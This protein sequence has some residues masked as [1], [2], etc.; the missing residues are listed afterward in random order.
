MHQAN[1]SRQKLA[2]VRL[3]VPKRASPRHIP[4][5]SL[6]T[7]MQL[8]HERVVAC[9]SK[10]GVLQMDLYLLSRASTMWDCGQAIVIQ[11]KTHATNS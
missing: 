8:H 7:C 5:L 11:L 1:I 2:V 6:W 4:S 9:D 10:H 3:F